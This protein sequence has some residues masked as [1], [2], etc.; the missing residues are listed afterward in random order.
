MMH[1]ETI[2]AILVSKN[3]E[4][5][6]QLIEILDESSDIS[7]VFEHAENLESAIGKV[8][9]ERL[10]VM[11]LDIDH[12]EHNGI[13]ALLQAR[14]YAG[15]LPIIALTDSDDDQIGASLIRAGAEDF[16]IKKQL[17][18]PLLAR[19]IRYSIEHKHLYQELNN[20][21]IQ[22]EKT[23]RALEQAIIKASQFAKNELAA[24][25][26]K[27]RFLT[28]LNHEIRTPIN[29]IVPMLGLLLEAEL[30]LEQYDL[31]RMASISAEALLLI[32]NDLLDATR[33]DTSKLDLEIIDFELRT[34]L[35]ET[36]N[37]LAL[38]AHDKGLEYVCL[39]DRS[40]PSFVKGDP[41]R[42][43]QI[44][45]NVVGNAVK[46]T[47]EGEVIL[48][49]TLEDQ[50]SERAYIRFAVNDSGVGISEEKIATLFNEDSYAESSDA[51][52]LGTDRSGL[53]ISKQ[54]VEMMNGQIGVESQPG[55][56]STFWFTALLEKQNIDPAMAIEI[57]EAL[58]DV[59][60]L[61]VDD[62]ATVRRVCSTMLSAWNC[63]CHEARDATSALEALREAAA[64]KDPFLVAL[65]DIE[66]PDIGGRKLGDLILADSNLNKTK[67]ILMTG[68]MQRG[69]AH[70]LKKMGFSTSLTKPL[71]RKQLYDSLVMVLGRDSI[72]NSATESVLT[73]NHFMSEIEKFALRILVVEDNIVN[74]KVATKLLLNLGYQADVVENGLEAVRAL[75][76]SDYDLVLM[77]LQMPQ[78][79]GFEATRI[80]RDSTSEVRNHD[81][82][83]IAMTAH[84]LKGARGKCLEIGMNDYIPKPIESD[85]LAEVIEKWTSHLES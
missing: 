7:I 13:E 75:I 43:R 59:R 48:N 38:K 39:I 62:S 34:V 49:V 77:D 8:H 55:T 10:N 27:H 33:M 80:I 53:V 74:Q 23:N 37:L 26:A 60:V 45:T 63:P 17:T 51:S 35:E 36:N 20:A 67:L 70:R 46:Y 82:P 50:D 24:D 5:A 6:S 19:S 61:I 16:L 66:L 56:G 54:L 78:M 30:D 12:A 58:P 71:R 65:I 42:L 72:S 57:A 76:T 68:F 32:L 44:L 69:E 84:T 21:N 15:Q 85:F 41:G 47:R 73:T 83:I 25:M 29:G 31:A 81:V 79:D 3:A 52:D 9:S 28:E 1:G 64:D 2:R 11:L 22:L 40:I 4:D 14:E 18:P